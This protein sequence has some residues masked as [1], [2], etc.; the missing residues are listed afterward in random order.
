MT[1][2]RSSSSSAAADVRRIDVRTTDGRVLHVH[3]DGEPGDPRVP[4]VLHHGAPMS[5][6]MLPGELADARQRGIRLIGYDRPGYGGSTR[7]PGRR[8]ADVV[9]D[10]TTIA[11]ALGVD[12]FLTAG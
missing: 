8:V 9:D 2:Q 1:S 4:L 10:V 11:D 5:A 3:D 12:R 6:L 7:R